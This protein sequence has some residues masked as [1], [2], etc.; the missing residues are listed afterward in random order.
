MPRTL[1]EIFAPDALPLTARDKWAEPFH[2]LLTL[3]TARTGLPDLSAYTAVAAP[4]AQPAAP[5]PAQIAAEPAA[6]AM[7]A[8]VPHAYQAFVTQA[9]QVHQRLVAVGEN[10]AAA[11]LGQAAPRERAGEI[12]QLFSDAAERHRQ[13]LG[14]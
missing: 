2:T 8:P 11:P 10:E 6:S 3:A 7:A 14:R 13:E 1:R 12:T 9:E 5:A 4:R